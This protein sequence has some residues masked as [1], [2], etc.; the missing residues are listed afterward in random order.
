MLPRL[1]VGAT[2]LSVINIVVFGFIIF[3]PTFFVQEGLSIVRSMGFTTL[4][5]LGAPV[6]ALIPLVTAD[7]FGRK[8]SLIVSALLAA[9]IGS[10]YPLVHSGPALAAVGFSLLCMVYMNSVVCFAMY[11]PELFPTEVRLRGT[12]VCNTIGRIVGAIVP[13]VIVPLYQGM[14]IFGVVSLMVAALVFQAVVV[15]I[16]GVETRGQSLEALAASVAETAAPAHTQGIVA[17]GP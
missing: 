5:T 12:G 2:T 4:M 7:R 6:G 10:V 15:G 1:L 3:I 17:P 8:W 11:V 16:W 13:M 9:V 14:G